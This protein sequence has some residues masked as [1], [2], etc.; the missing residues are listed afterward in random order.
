MARAGKRYPLLL[1]TRMMDRWWPPVFMIGLAMLALGWWLYQD[2]YT[3]LTQPWQWVTMAGAGLLAIVAA[4][5]MLALRKSAYVQAFGDHFLVATPLLRMNV[6]YKRIQRTTSVG[7]AMLFPTAKMSFLRRDTI[8]PL[9]S[10]TALIVELSAL[11]I[12]RSTLRLFLSPFFFKDDTPHIVLVVQNW[13]A[14]STEL[15]SLR[16]KGNA[17]ARTERKS[18]PSILA[19]LPKK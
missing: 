13:M 7:M 4:L 10:R 3:R 5:V 14:F 1:Y 12:S 9:L 11:P 2:V 6:S 17:P 8:E 16:V 18:Q 15:E 19:Q